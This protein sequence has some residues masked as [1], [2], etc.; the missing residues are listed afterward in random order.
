MGPRNAKV[1]W[2]AAE[3]K[4]RSPDQHPMCVEASLWEILLQ[5]ENM[6]ME[7]TGWSEA[8]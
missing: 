1:P 4:N 2:V 6:K 7:P 5:R 8:E 3:K